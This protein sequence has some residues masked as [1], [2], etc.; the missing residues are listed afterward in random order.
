MLDAEPFKS[1]EHTKSKGPV[2]Y[3]ALPDVTPKLLQEEAKSQ[4]QIAYLR[5]LKKCVSPK[6]CVLDDYKS[7]IFSV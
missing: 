6:L 3:S 4:L 1:T 5:S 7:M 2:I